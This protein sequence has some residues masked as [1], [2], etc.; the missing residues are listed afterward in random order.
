MNRVHAHTC[1]DDAPVALWRSFLAILVGLL[2]AVLADLAGWLL[3]EP[4][5]EP[6]AAQREPLVNLTAVADAVAERHGGTVVAMSNPWGLSDSRP[7]IG[8]VLAADLRW[9]REANRM[10]G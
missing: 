3:R 1:P 10:N 4:R 8:D 7:V 5:A 2:I 9:A 6:A